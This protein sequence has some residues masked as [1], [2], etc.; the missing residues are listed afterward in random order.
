MENSFLELD[1]SHPYRRFVSL[2]AFRYI[3]SHCDRYEIKAHLCLFDIIER[4]PVNNTRWDH[5]RHVKETMPDPPQM[6]MNQYYN[7]LN[8]LLG[9]TLTAD[10]MR[11][12]LTEECENEREENKDNEDEMKAIED[13]LDHMSDEST[14]QFWIGL[15]LSGLSTA[16]KIGSWIIEQFS[17]GAM[18]VGESVLGAVTE[19]VINGIKFAAQGVITIG[20]RLISIGYEAVVIG[21]DTI[22]NLIT[23]LIANSAAI[24]EGSVWLLYGHL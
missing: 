12:Y 3:V 1:I 14:K 22:S 24:F 23:V 11:R 18:A 17:S 6:V 8:Y 4:I 7:A 19:I 13:R 2:S 15:C 10:E 16:F 21:I 20:S 5:M 9:V